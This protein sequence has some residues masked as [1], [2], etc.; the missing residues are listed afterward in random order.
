MLNILQGVG[1]K[2]RC[3][4]PKVPQCNQRKKPPLE[5]VASALGE[6]VSPGTAAATWGK[7]LKFAGC[8]GRASPGLGSCG[9]AIAAR[10]YTSG[11]HCGG[12]Y[13][14]EFR[15]SVE[16]PEA[17]WGEKAEQLTWFKKWSKTLENPDP[18]FVRWFVDGEFNICYNAIDRHIENGCGDQIAIIYDSPVTSTKETITY[19]EV[20][21]QVSKLAGVLVKHGVKKGD[22]VTIYMPMIPQAMYTMLACARI[23]AIHSLI[24]GGFASKELSVR[25]DHAKPVLVVTA[26]YGIEPG[27]RIEYIPLLERALE[28][29]QHKPKKILIY[30]RPNT[31]NVPMIP[32]RDLSWHEEMSTAKP[33]DC[34]SVSSEHPLYIL[35]TSGTTGVPKGIVRPS[36]GYAVML[37]WTMSA[38]YGINPGEVWW[39]ASDLGWVVGHS[40]ICYA[41]L[42]HG[43]TTVLYEGKPVGTPDAGAFFR[44]LA[45]YGVAALF[46][47]PTAIRA[48]RQQDPEASLGQQYHPTRSRMLFLAGERCDVETLEWSKKVFKVPVLDH[49]WQT[50]T[51]SPITASCVGLGNSLTPPPG[52]AGKPVPG[53]NVMILDNALQPEKPKTLG[54]I[55]VKL[56]LP[57]GALSSL[58]ENNTAFK[59]YYFKKFPGYYNT[60]DAGYMDEDGYFYI[61]SRVDDVINVAGHRLSAGAI[62]ESIMYHSAVVDCAVVGLEDSLKGHV[63]MAF[64]VLRYGVVQKEEKLSEEIVRLVRENIG[65]IAAVR[66]IIFV[67]RLPKTR[68]GKIPRSILSALANGKPYEVTPTIEDPDV[69]SEIEKVMKHKL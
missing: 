46:T 38:I 10:N 15:T 19:R 25:I 66:K 32:G 31:E 6:S 24:F 61:M 57:P 3:P 40:Y 30:N 2:S 41:P 16:D 42:L 43:N 33:H 11:T 56:P 8:W 58:W 18:P 45:E 21:E 5:K 52:Q 13:E 48:I 4:P 54:N 36:A 68:S 53:Y 34:V 22:R 27:R 35:Y 62:E 26:S 44:L 65:S 59:E 29:V 12:R 7:S 60:M 28:I 55:V 51:G 14:R 47:A 1:L 67:K 23:G 37:N 49:W 64:C 39:A 17:F 20:F 69:F 9:G 63:P 50:E